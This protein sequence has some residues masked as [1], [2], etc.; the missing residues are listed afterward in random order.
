MSEAGRLGEQREKP[1][2]RE[3]SILCIL[4]YH[5][6]KENA[7]N[8]YSELRFG[9]LVVDGRWKAVLPIRVLC[10]LKNVSGGKLDTL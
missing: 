6:E 7:I 10:P 8:I 4:N 3:Y 9:R 2:F 1:C 5:L